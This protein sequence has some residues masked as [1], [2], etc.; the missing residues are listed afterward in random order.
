MNNPISLFLEKKTKRLRILEHMGFWFSY[1]AFYVLYIAFSYNTCII[2]G[3]RDHGL[4]LIIDIAVSYFI[5]FLTDKYLEKKKYLIL[6][7]LATLTILTGI[8]LYRITYFYIVSRLFYG[9]IETN[10]WDY[11]ILDYAYGL[12]FPV[13]IINIL[14]LIRKWVHSQKEMYEMAKSKINQELSFLKIQLNQHFLFNTLNNIDSLIYSDPETASQTIVNL[15]NLLRY[16]IYETDVMR[17]PAKK[18]IEYIITFI[19]LYELRLAENNKIELKISGDYENLIIMP[20]L[21]I[22]FVE[23]ALIYGK[24]DDDSKIYIS[25]TFCEKKVILNTM[26][27]IKKMEYDKQGGVGI[28]N[29]QRTLDIAYHNRYK[30]EIINKDN[31]YTVKL[32][33]DLED[34][35]NNELHYCG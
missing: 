3:I 24:K 2:L 14:H 31:W 33:I 5:I 17:V 8:I 9:N 1:F 4:Y 6:I 30:L 13:A 19:E 20:R 25:I 28:R 29:V 7:I 21:F 34:E 32:L 18:E 35:R 26:N 12:F 11:R 27:Q 23:N 15:S 10:F 16:S 22:P